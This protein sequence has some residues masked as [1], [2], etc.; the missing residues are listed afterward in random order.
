MDLEFLLCNSGDKWWELRSEWDELYHTLDDESDE[1]D[2]YTSA[3]LNALGDLARQSDKRSAVYIVQD[4][5]EK[6]PQAVFWGNVARLPKMNG[7]TLRIR[8]FVLSPDYVYGS[9]NTDD[10][11]SILS[12]L[13]NSACMI[14]KENGCDNV[15][16]Y[17]QTPGDLEFFIKY[18]D[19]LIEEDIF[20]NV[21]YHGSWFTFSFS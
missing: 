4:K 17:F 11:R 21:D 18:K 9:K 20:S 12:E 5:I 10:Y 16:I 14:A 13:F 6:T 8:H 19:A 1:S 15:K 3:S 7:K 2:E